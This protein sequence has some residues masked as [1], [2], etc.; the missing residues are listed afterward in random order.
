MNTTIQNSKCNAEIKPANGFTLLDVLL[1]IV[2]FA[3]G[4]L[5]LA[6]LQTNLTRSSIDSNA[7]M[8]AVNMGEEIIERLRAFERVYSDPDGTA[9]AFEDI[10]I[11]YVGNFVGKRG[12]LSYKVVPAESKVYGYTFNENG[13]DVT[14]TEPLDPTEEYD[15]KRVELTIEWEAAQD[16]IVD[17]G[18]TLATGDMNSGKITIEGIISSIPA[19]STA[20]LAADEEGDG[21][22]PVIYTPGA[23]PDIVA[24]NVEEGK[25]KESTT[26]LPEIVKSD[27]SS[28]TWFDVITYNGTAANLFV[29]RE[30]FLVVSCECTLR[31]G[32]G[33]GDGGFLPTIWNGTEYVTGP[34][35]DGDSYV[36][37]D[38]FV[39]KL[40]GESTSNT[41]GVDYCVT[42]CRDH[43]D[44][45]NYDS[46]DET[47]DPSRLSDPDSAWTKPATVGVPAARGNHAHYSRSKKGELTEVGIG[48]T[49]VEACRM[50]RKDGFM[51]VAQDFRQEGFNAFPEGYLETTAGAD[52][53]ADYVIK[54]VN[55]FYI[56]SRD[57][58]TG[59]D[60]D[61][62][63]GQS[64]WGSFTFP[65]TVTNP[66]SLPFPAIGG[67]DSQQMRSRG[68]YIDHLGAE[69]KEA[70]DC[71]IANEG[72]ANI[73]EICETP[74]LDNYLQAFPFFEMQTTFLSDWYDQK[75]MGFPVRVTS[76]AAETNNEHSRGYATLLDD[77][78]AEVV[79]QTDMHRGNSGLSVTDPISPMDEMVVARDDSEVFVNVSGG[80]VEAS[81]PTA[82]VWTGTLESAV[83]G[84]NALDAEIVPINDNNYCA[85]SGV[86]IS[87]MTVI[88]ASGG[89]T[90]SGYYKNAGT[91]LWICSNN[92]ALQIDNS[93][94][95]SASKSATVT[96]N[97]TG[98][99][100]DVQLSI[101][102]SACVP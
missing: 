44:D 43:H 31:N 20:Q 16:F 101:E 41:P 49:Y 13:T 93:N 26:P 8:V 52:A 19:F 100:K 65:G 57:V 12:G 80:G 86:T 36:E 25:L 69:A 71:L 79:V 4:M 6:S 46:A 92:A 64:L 70:V 72:A 22:V 95:A 66:T 28:E 99:I 51:R 88:G 54:A 9:Y 63:T 7:R 98:N 90:I 56:N 96:W 73:S 50:V 84:V 38:E 24:L 82:Y 5:A 67:I 42:C 78:P 81:N 55:D 21:G 62:G 3:V 35:K 75:K 29:R 47:H 27:G 61:D 37:R 40:Y 85:R 15:F 2:V 91:S 45:S 11:D 33:D 32:G 59:P 76:E 18:T 74:G 10:D 14:V 39:N 53:Y 89:V 94:A 97:L 34:V 30:E 1:G 48:Q 58:L 77:A 17:D 60:G 23:K 68:I 102:S 83:N 87:C